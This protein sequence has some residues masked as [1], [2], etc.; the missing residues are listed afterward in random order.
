MKN[1]TIFIVAGENSGDIHA[2]KLMSHLKTIVPG[3]RFI[4]IGGKRMEAEGLRTIIQLDKISVVGIVEVLK[5]INYI[6][7]AFAQ[8]K[9]I[10]ESKNLDLVVLVDFPGFNLKIAELARRNKIPVCYYI[11][12]QLWAWGKKRIYKLQKFVDLLLVVFPFEKEF[13]SPYVSNLE[14]VGHPLLDEPVFQMEL[15]PFEKRE[16]S[17][18]LLPGSRKSEILHHKKLTLDLIENISKEIPGY[19]I[20]IPLSDEKFFEVFSKEIK[21]YR[22]NVNFVH[23]SFE[24]LRNSKVGLIK[25]GTANLEAALLGL[26]FVMFYKTSFWTY[27]IAKRLIE[28]D[29]I[30]IVNILLKG[31][32]VPEFIQKNAVPERIVEVIKT[33]LQ[34]NNIYEGYQRICSRVK[35]LLGGKGASERAARKIVEIFGL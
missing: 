25:S 1:P 18:A 11:A 32:Y 12:P 14:F 31:N 29:Y 30:S 17:I 7:S 21:S 2:S 24:I 9:R 22:G 6:R 16:N 10:L 34:D 33:I 15:L 4:G 19:K 23:N 5:N 8:S 20:N 26:P 27:L 3:I 28:I 13:F 35:E